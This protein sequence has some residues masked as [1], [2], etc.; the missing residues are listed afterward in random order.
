[1]LGCHWPAC[2]DSGL[3]GHKYVT[4]KLF[5]GV[6][7]NYNIAGWDHY[8]N[9]YKSTIGSIGLWKLVGSM[10]WTTFLL[11][12]TEAIGCNLAMFIFITIALRKIKKQYQKWCHLKCNMLWIIHVHPLHNIKQNGQS[13][14][15]LKEQQEHYF[16][17]IYMGCKHNTVWAKCGWDV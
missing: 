10:S 3:L 11:S 4:L 13:N 16:T 9:W 12:M 2:T 15:Q 7:M 14:E 8:V 5:Q 6:L 1:M 17:T